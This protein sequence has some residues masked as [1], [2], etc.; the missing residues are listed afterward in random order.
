MPAGLSAP[1]GV[2]VQAEFLSLSAQGIAVDS[3]GLGGLTHVSVVLFEQALDETLLEFAYGLGVL[4]SIFD[5]AVDE[6]FELVFHGGAPVR[7]NLLRL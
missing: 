7:L 1:L 3:Q 4:N 5:H 2:V 6:S